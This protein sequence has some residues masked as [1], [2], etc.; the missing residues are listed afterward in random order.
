MG[1]RRP[2]RRDEQSS[3]GRADPVEAAGT[4]RTKPAGVGTPRPLVSERVEAAKRARGRAELM[5]QEA[6]L[7]EQGWSLKKDKAWVKLE[8]G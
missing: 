7:R 4:G 3:L 6:E 1:S 2:R 5:E 8:E